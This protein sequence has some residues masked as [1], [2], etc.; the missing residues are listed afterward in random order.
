MIYE[1]IVVAGNRI[2]SYKC[3][4]LWKGSFNCFQSTDSWS[5]DSMWNYSDYDINARAVRSHKTSPGYAFLCILFEIKQYPSTGGSVKYCWNEG[6]IN[7]MWVESVSWS[8]TMLEIVIWKNIS[9][10]VWNHPLK[11][12]FNNNFQQFF[13]H[14][15]LKNS[16]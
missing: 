14:S 9:Y 5:F 13:N 4:C 16:S 2:Y 11:S 1:F 3:C 6:L 7:I 8:V 12:S 15:I 10:I